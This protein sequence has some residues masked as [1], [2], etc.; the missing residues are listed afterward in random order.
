[1]VIDAATK[2]LPRGAGSTNDSRRGVARK[3][4]TSS[5]IS[6]RVEATLSTAAA[7]GLIQGK[8]LKRLSGRTHEGLLAA[9]MAKSG[10]EGGDL[11]EYALA[12]VALE[13]DFA[14]RLLCREG[15][16]SQEV[17]LGI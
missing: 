11:L 13:D 4:P 12:K 17:D 3:A 5:A 8:K 7:T 1:M 10:L 16:I 9:A 14:E 2:K 6:R 15:T